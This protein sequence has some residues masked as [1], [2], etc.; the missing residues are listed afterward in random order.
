MQLF[1]T[2]CSC[3]DANSQT[4][5]LYT[6]NVVINF[7]NDKHNQS[8]DLKHKVITEISSVS[9]VSMK[10]RLAS[11]NLKKKLAQLSHILPSCNKAHYYATTGI[12]A[13]LLEQ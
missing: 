3:N 13:I 1:L 12:D 7:L 6:D 8:I 9:T 11:F 10:P 2:G 5:D 4:I